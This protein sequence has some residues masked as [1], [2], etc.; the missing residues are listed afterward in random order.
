M[1]KLQ[2]K[3]VLRL[4]DNASIPM[5]NGNRDYEEYKEWLANG[6]VPEP[7]DVVNTIKGDAQ[8][9]LDKTDLVAIRC[10][11]AGVAFPAEW[12]SYVSALRAIVSGADTTSV[13]LPVMP[14]YPAGT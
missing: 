12:K 2:G 7:E 1:Y 5:A 13:S 9:A 8:F 14:A 3:S 4:S 6:G 10:V 11:K